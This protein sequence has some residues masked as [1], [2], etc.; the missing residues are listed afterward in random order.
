ML[1]ERRGLALPVIAV[2]VA[3]TWYHLAFIAS[4]LIGFNGYLTDQT[5]ARRIAETPGMT[6]VNS[7]PEGSRVLLIGEAQVFE[8]RRP[9]L[10]S[11]VFNDNVFE[12]LFRA[13]D[14][15][16]AMK[17]AAE[18]RKTLRDNGVTHVLV[19]WNEVLRY[20]TT[21]GY[22]DFVTPG[23]VDLLERTGI[24]TREALP[25]SSPSVVKVE[26]QGDSTKFQLETWG[27]GLVRRDPAGDWFP[28]YELWRVVE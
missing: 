6:I 10:Y 3:T 1:A 21:Y 24:V 4:P 2:L 17:T 27:A 12:E 15:K 19:N 18:I 5:V 9:V 22:T 26:G 11:T 7:L 25:R 14:A 13:D 28:A 16:P 20:R 23:N 8:A